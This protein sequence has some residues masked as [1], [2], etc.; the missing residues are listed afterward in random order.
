MP[1]QYP[2]SIFL[3]PS[4]A[5]ARNLWSKTGESPAFT[6]FELGPGMCGAQGDLIWVSSISAT[7]G[8]PTV[9]ASAGS[10]TTTSAVTSTGSQ[11]VNVAS[12]AIFNAGTQS[13]NA[14]GYVVARG[15]A[16]QEIIF[17]T[18]STGT[19]S[20]TAVFGKTHLSG[21]TIE[22]VIFVPN[23]G[24][25]VDSQG[26]THPAKY[27]YIPGAG[28]TVDN[29]V[30]ANTQ[31][32]L[33]DDGTNGGLTHTALTVTDQS[34]IPSQGGT[35]IKFG[36]FSI[37]QAGFLN[38]VAFVIYGGASHAAVKSGTR[39]I[40][41]GSDITSITV[42][43]GSLI[44]GLNAGHGF[45]VSD[46]L[47]VL[48]VAGLTGVFPIT[49]VTSTSATVTGTYGG[50]YV[51]GGV[52]A[53]VL[54]PNTAT[55]FNYGHDCATLFAPLSFAFYGIGFASANPGAS[56]IA[57]GSLTTFG[58]GLTSQIASYI[59][60]CTVTISTNAT[61][62][63]TGVTGF[64]N[65]F[66]G[67]ANDGAWTNMVSSLT[68]NPQQFTGPQFN[69][70][71]GH[72]VLF[73]KGNY[74][75]LNTIN[76]SVVRMVVNNSMQAVNIVFDPTMTPASM[77]VN[78]IDLKPQ[79]VLG[80]LQLFD[81][82]GSG[83]HD[84]T[85]NGMSVPGATNVVFERQE[86]GCILARIQVFQ[87]SKRGFVFV[88]PS[89]TAASRLWMPGGS[90]W[91]SFPLF[92]IRVTAA[93]TPIVGTVTT[94][95]PSGGSV[96]IGFAVDPATLGFT[97]GGQVAISGVFGVY[98]PYAIT[99]INSGAHTLTFTLT[100]TG[101][102]PT[103]VV[104]AAGV[105]NVAVNKT[106]FTAGDGLVGYGVTE[107][108][109][110]FN[111]VRSERMSN[112]TLVVNDTTISCAPT[113][114][115][116]IG[117][118]IVVGPANQAYGIQ[119]LSPAGTNSLH[120]C[121]VNIGG[122]NSVW[123]IGTDLQQGFIESAQHYESVMIGSL[124]PLDLNFSF[125]N[126]NVTDMVYVDSGIQ[127]CK[128]R[129]ISAYSKAYNVFDAMTGFA[130]NNYN[131]SIYQSSNLPNVYACSGVSGSYD[132]NYTHSGLGMKADNSGVQIGLL[133][134]GDGSSLGP[135]LPFGFP[136]STGRHQLRAFSFFQNLAG[137]YGSSNSGSSFAPV[138]T[139][140]VF[141]H[142]F[143]AMLYFGDGATQGNL[144]PI[145]ND[146]TAN[147]AYFFHGNTSA[148]DLEILVSTNSGTT[149]NP[150]LTIHIPTRDVTVPAALNAATLHA[151]NGATATVGTPV[152]VTVVNG[153][154]TAIS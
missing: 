124:N 14:L 22:C 100:Y 131:L 98:G 54:Q 4:P 142:V 115:H 24:G 64:Q 129:N 94:W 66:F 17:P 67:T 21:V 83:A 85:V 18:S 151:G 20:I 86:E 65:A 28:P 106:G 40:V 130:D 8:S 108:W 27:V 77:V 19:P 102:T 41:Y 33:S 1:T 69:G 154:V 50:T 78:G 9:T 39:T 134:V 3:S 80:D 141:G 36:T 61:T 7:A 152:S 140:D 57:W 12:L 89:E 70:Q 109:M 92:P 122:F 48:Q 23:D 43:G 58:K 62:T 5:D 6:D 133:K 97:V 46:Q 44:I 150:A 75:F 91:D 135:V 139:W 51:S 110:G 10:T 99:A 143:A 101:A 137:F 16:D 35:K 112:S 96:I 82:F 153:I 76:S 47:S 120:D 144:L 123:G 42:S 111:T 30:V 107:I 146:I 113:Q 13:F 114:T 81:R 132:F 147:R 138:L 72:G 79:L 125:G 31:G 90:G 145:G 55:G 26:R 127:E 74:L 11:T 93:V 71:G 49:A 88:N 38:P 52:A 128:I 103:N 29:L 87:H 126:H 105:Q 116:P 32:G 63:V 45:S 15:A 68:Q 60:P 119:A 37:G 118:A 95:T 59:D 2:H 73:S 117:E 56:G 121:T 34:I 84:L 104:T 25:Y 149:K 53:H 148:Q 136:V